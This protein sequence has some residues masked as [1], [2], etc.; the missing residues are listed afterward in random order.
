MSIG[1]DGIRYADFIYTILRQTNIAFTTTQ[2]WLQVKLESQGRFIF[3]SK[4]KVSLVKF[5]RTWSKR[6]ITASLVIS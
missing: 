3:C 5:T 2:C 1:H 4:S 6:K